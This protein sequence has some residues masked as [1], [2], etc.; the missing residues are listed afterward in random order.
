MD[1]TGI[2]T[3]AKFAGGLMDR[4]FPKKMDES[5]RASVQVQLTEALEQREA[6]VVN[7]QKDVMVAE[8]NQSDNY[9]KR[10]R[11]TIVYFGLVVIGLNHVIL[12]WAA[13]FLVEIYEKT[14]QL[15]KIELPTE[16]WYTWGGVCSVWVWG[17][18]KEKMGSKEK[19]ISMIT[20]SK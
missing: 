7:S 8:L 15:P 3:A 17:R 4:F 1:L 14:V 18:S 20:G 6:E 13:W 5:E 12:P 11:P 2:G 19:I 9:T 16:F 10:A